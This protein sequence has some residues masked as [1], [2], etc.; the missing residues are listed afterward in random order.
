MKHIT[1][2]DIVESEFFFKKKEDEP[3][4]D[5][6]QHFYPSSNDISKS[7]GFSFK[8]NK[9]IMFQ[10][11]IPMYLIKE[12]IEEEFDDVYVMF[13]PLSICQI[14]LFID[15]ENLQ[16]IYEN[17][18]KKEIACDRDSEYYIELFMYEIFRPKLFDITICGI[19]GIK[20]LVY[21]LEKKP[22]CCG[23]NPLYYI[24]LATHLSQQLPYQVEKL[25][26][27]LNRALVFQLG[28]QEGVIKISN[29]SLIL[30]DKK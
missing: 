1:W 9:K 21:W 10:Y 7:M 30:K 11:Q 5:A 16:N 29:K 17:E 6:F 27:L 8:L 28:I 18:S 20:D 4:F 2:A 12:R 25:A 14:D 22:G 3:W 26:D 19:D 24:T 23:T 15:F 13:S